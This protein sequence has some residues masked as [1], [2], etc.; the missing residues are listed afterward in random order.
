V[1]TNLDSKKVAVT[2]HNGVADVA[3]GSP[4][5]DVVV[6]LQRQDGGTIY[7]SAVVPCKLPP[8]TPPPTPLPPGPKPPVVPPMPPKKPTPPPIHTS[9]KVFTIKTVACS[10]GHR[11]Y[12]IDRTRVT[13][14]R[15]G[16]VIRIAWSQPVKVW[17]KVCP[18]PG[19]TG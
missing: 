15:G 2:V 3:I 19:V 9:R 1:W 6:Y 17:G 13:I 12:R 7:Q 14:T 16:N 11:S 5:G 8:V 10:V 18:L 4:E